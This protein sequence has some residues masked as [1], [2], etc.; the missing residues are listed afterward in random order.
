MRVLVTGAGGYVGR[1]VVAALQVAG[2]EPVAALH[3]SD[4]LGD[5]EHCRVDLLEPESLRAP[6]RNVEGVVHLAGLT[7][8]RES[9]ADPLQ[10]FNVNVTGTLSLL[11]AMKAEDVG[12]LVFASTGAIYGSPDV[13]QMSEALPA[14]PPHPYAASKYAA[15]LAVDAMARSG[16]LGAVVIRLFSAAGGADPD[17]TRIVPR[18]LAAAA[19]EVDHLHI[20]GDG[21]AVRDLLHVDSAAQAFIAA[22]ER[23]P[24]IGQVDCYN[25]GSGMGTSVMDV[26][27]AAER[28][29]GRRVPVVHGPP[30]GEPARLVCDPSRAAEALDWKPAHS[31]VDEIVRSAWEARARAGR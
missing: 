12:R 5:V 18:V 30:A 26:V 10:Y 25:I 7:L 17:P 23:V 28:I 8:A 6:L 20:N 1:A 15:E 19:G 2:H 14:D 13:Q 3:Q 29:T 4:S 31:A 27:R 16:Q 22:L 24:E 11:S 9:W 21:S